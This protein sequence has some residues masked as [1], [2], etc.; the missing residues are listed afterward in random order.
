M[1]AS[2]LTLDMLQVSVEI[3]TCGF[4]DVDEELLGVGSNLGS[5]SGADEL[6]N[7]LPVFAVHLEGYRNKLLDMLSRNR[8]NKT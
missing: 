8:I 4:L 3:H 6:L 7:L 5:R 1:V 2:G